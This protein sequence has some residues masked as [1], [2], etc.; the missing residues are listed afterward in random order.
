[1]QQDR[2]EPLPAPAG[3][4]L[5]VDNIGKAFRGRTVV[6][7]VTLS[8][9]R[10]EVLRVIRYIRQHG[11][12]GHLD[13]PKYSLMGLPL[14]SGSIESAIRRVINLRMK[15]NGTF[16]RLPKAERI[17]VLRASILSGRWDQDRERV[18]RGMQKS[19]KLAMPPI[20]ESNLSKTDARLAPLETQ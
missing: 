2:F 7:G 9:D 18:K 13:Y 8:L 14:G 3:H 4:G 19:R 6:R 12:A 16:W 17:L 1:M 15:S 11:E 20:R 5:V 10:G